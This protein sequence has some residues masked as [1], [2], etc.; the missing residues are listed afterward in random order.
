MSSVAPLKRYGQHFLRNEQVAAKIVSAFL[1][2]A[3]NAAT[4]RLNVLEIG[5]GEGI[6]TKYLVN[7]HGVN[8]KLIEIDKRFVEQLTQS[9]PKLGPAIIQADI[10][11]FNLQTLFEGEPFSIIGN[12]PYNISSQIVF[13]VIENRQYIKCVHGMFQYEVAKRLTATHGNKDYGITT[14]LLQAYYHTKRVLT[15]GNKLFYPPP[16]VQSAMVQFT[17]NNVSKLKC[18]EDLF[19]KVVKAAFNKRRKVLRNSLAGFEGDWAQIEDKMLG[20]R[21]EQ[22]SIE[23]FVL[24]TRAF[25]S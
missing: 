2:E 8:L 6:L 24:I 9:F 7:D 15:V 25:E 4:G 18:D 11:K 17:R 1:I 21:A 5:P 19:K 22:L 13:K 12:L 10:L 20:L 23:D 3:Q 14:V 16:K